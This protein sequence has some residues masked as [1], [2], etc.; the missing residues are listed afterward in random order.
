MVEHVSTDWK[1][2]LLGSIFLPLKVAPMRI[3]NNFNGHLIEK[4][5]KLND[6]NK[7]VFENRQILVPRT[8]NALQYFGSLYCKQYGP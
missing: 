5:P 2:H 7:S 4:P 3:E 6:A 8:L 1:P